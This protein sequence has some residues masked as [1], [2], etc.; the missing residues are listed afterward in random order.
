[1]KMRGFI[2]F[3]TAFE[4]GFVEDSI[5]FFEESGHIAAIR[6]RKNQWSYSS[7]RYDYGTSVMAR[8]LN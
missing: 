3:L 1:M 2:R 6:V 5:K 8:L 7:R 4:T